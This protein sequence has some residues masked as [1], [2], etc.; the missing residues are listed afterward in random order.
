MADVFVSYKRDQRSVVDALSAKLRILGLSVWFDAS[1]NAG[2]AFS[3]EIDREAQAAKCV[4]V[5]WSPE[6][7]ESRWVRSE[8][9]IGFDQDKLAAAYVSGPDDFYAPA[10]FNTVHLEDLRGWLQSLDDTHSGWRS[11]L[12]RIGK[13]TRRRDLEAW[14]ALDAQAT[15]NELRTWLS[16]YPD[17]PALSAIQNMLQARAEQNAER[18]KREIEAREKRDRDR[19]E[20]ARKR[21]AERRAAAMQSARRES[22]RIEAERRASEAGLK[23]LTQFLLRVGLFVGV[24]VVV[25]LAVV[26]VPTLMDSSATHTSVAHI[27]TADFRNV[28]SVPTPLLRDAPEILVEDGACPGEGC[29]WGFRWRALRD[30]QSFEAPPATLGTTESDLQSAALIPEGSW[31]TAVTARIIAR[32]ANIV[33]TTEH[34]AT[35]YN[36][37]IRQG[38]VI[39]TY[40]HLGEGCFRAWIEQRF[41]TL[42]DLSDGGNAQEELWIQVRLADGSLVWTREQEHSFISQNGLDSDLATVLADLS[43]SFNQRL[44]RADSLIAQGAN[45]LGDG[46]LYGY[47]PVDGVVA[48]GDP[49]VLQAMLSRGLDLSRACPVNAAVSQ[50]NK[51]GSGAMLEA[52]FAN[53]MTVDCVS[54]DGSAI[55]SFLTFGIETRDYSVQNAIIT[56]RILAA[57]GAPINAADAAGQTIFNRIDSVRNNPSRLTPLR[58]ELERLAQAQ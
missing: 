22:E 51:D 24:G 25:L 6:A 27:R 52:L 5:C 1:L 9:M 14:G 18:A 15:E 20:L 13:L 46:G 31:T 34:E 33:A 23:Q 45:V 16:S 2:D 39:A 56:A 48:S 50:A 38:Q 55:V 4:L 10:P 47:A 37:A 17:S 21:E 32:R 11:L 53:G 58:E 36:P 12:R 26:L 54:R 57:H 28:D 40:Y 19:A 7:R 29:E 49:R 30:I 42:C 3:D 8:A 41:W 44:E 43:L 35:P